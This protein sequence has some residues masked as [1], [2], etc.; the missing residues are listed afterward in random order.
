MTEY[1]NYPSA[2]K[3][4]GELVQINMRM[5]KELAN[6]DITANKALANVTEM[7][8]KDNNDARHRLGGYRFGMTTEER[9]QA[10]FLSMVAYDAELNTHRPSVGYVRDEILSQVKA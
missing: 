9:Y 10:E 4:I 5:F 1:T 2:I 8:H 3:L 6:V 7:L